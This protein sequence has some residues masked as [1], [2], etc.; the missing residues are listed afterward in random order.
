M[1]KLLKVGLDW[2]DTLCPF[3]RHAVDLCN[4]ENGTKY[5]VDDIT[6]WGDSTPI[7]KKVSPYYGDERTYR[8]QVVTEDTKI[9]VRRL[10]EIA[11]VY[12][13]TAVSPRFMGVR[14][15][16]I[17]KA[18]P[19]FPEDHILMGAAKNLIKMDVLL[20]DGPHNILK[21]SATYPVLMRQPWNQNLSG[22]LSVNSLSEF[23][24]LVDQIINQMTETHRVE[25]PC[26]YAIVGP[27]GALKHDLAYQIASYKGETNCQEVASI[28]YDAD[29]QKPDVS[30]TDTI[31]AGNRYTLD[32]REITDRL[33]TGVSCVVVVDIG[34]AIALKREVPTVIIFCR[35]ARERMIENVLDDFNFRFISQSQATMQ[36]LSME[37]EL[38]NEVLCDYSVRS[39]DEQSIEQLLKRL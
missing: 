19:D 9:L 32:K 2:D 31:Y 22:V 26:V 37:Q 7:T 23:L 3:A 1:K 39:D 8:S 35:Q 5:S 36:L 21:A 27:S 25:D 4:K 15:E 20:D 18:F 34:G 33:N 38:R 24:V 14:A 13:V 16:Q 10:Q 29:Y 28:L 11:D 30:I 6:V 12:I 17:A